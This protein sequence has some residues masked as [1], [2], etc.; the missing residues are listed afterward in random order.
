MNRNDF[1]EIMSKRAGWRKMGQTA[2]VYTREGQDTNLGAGWY[3]GKARINL[4]NHGTVRPSKVETSTDLFQVLAHC[5][6]LAAIRQ[7]VA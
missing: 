6:L 2:Y 4:V 7:I 1:T 5:E 3:R